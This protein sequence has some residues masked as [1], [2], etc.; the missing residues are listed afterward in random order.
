MSSS[1]TQKFHGFF[2]QT[3][4]FLKDLREHNTQDWFDGHKEN[5][6][7]YLDQPLRDLFTDLGSFVEQTFSAF[8]WETAPK[9][10]KC[11][12]RIHIR[13]KSG[14]DLYY[15]H[16][17]GAF[18]RRGQTKQND[19]Q[20]F[21]DVGPEKVRVGLHIGPQAKKVW[22]RFQRNIKKSPHFF[23]SLLRELA[24]K[25]SYLFEAVKKLDKTSQ[26]LPE[27]RD[28]EALQTWS[29][30]QEITIARE[31]GLQESFLYQPE[32]IQRVQ[33]TFRDLYPFYI[34]ATV[35]DPLSKV[36]GPIG[37]A[38]RSS[39]PQVKETPSSPYQPVATIDQ[40][41]EDIEVSQA[42][43]PIYTFEQL[44]DETYLEESFLRGIETLLRGEKKQAIF[45]GPPG[46]GKTYVAQKFAQYLRGSEGQAQL[47]QFH[48]AY[49]YEEFIEGI[50][51]QVVPTN[52][53]RR[54]ISYSVER[55]IFK[56]FC[57]E[58]RRKKGRYVFII[59]EINRGN[60]PR[61]FGELLYLL[62]YRD[63]EII[64]PY[65]QERFS[66]PHNVYILG[67]MNTA[68]RSLALVDFALR[69]RFH[70]I[71]FEAN[72]SILKRW[73]EKKRPTMLDKVMEV[74]TL[75]DQAIEDKHFKIGFSYFMDPELNTYKLQLL[76]E[77]TLRPYLEEY[78][79]NEPS[80]VFRLEEKVKKILL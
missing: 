28:L 52:T 67:T 9:T 72:K 20:L 61:I 53:I 37:K 45:T 11:I 24:S 30:A 13:G 63:E 26:P 49:G 8:Q 19:A 60:I 35:S 27:V 43:Q 6:Y 17:W 66:I 50:R 42:I 59:D 32:L 44:L 40:T 16:Y 47:V 64:L 5:F 65:S 58:A 73:L 22:A 12:S 62:E 70:F 55:G 76:W 18:Y 41:S 4:T 31:W 75:L 78:W 10:G 77:Y 48:P 25:D 29:Q 69:R 2:S 1:L 51:P 79:F 34:F 46:T 80:R 71:P 14:V 68:D 15:T 39:L 36:N 38:R 23:Q 3:F 33:S 7:R 74:F 54:D 56:K 21:V 57:E